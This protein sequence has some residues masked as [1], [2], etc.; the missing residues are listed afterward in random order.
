MC[1]AGL[2]PWMAGL[3]YDTT[4]SYQWAF[5][6]CILVAAIGLT[7][8]FLLRPPARRNLVTPGEPLSGKV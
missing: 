3:I 2:G 6:I 5:V 1:G 8:V 4:K 7:M